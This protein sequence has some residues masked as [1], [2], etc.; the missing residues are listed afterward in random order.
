[1]VGNPCIVGSP[2]TWWGDLIKL[3]ILLSISGEILQTKM[4]VNL[5]MGSRTLLI[6]SYLKLL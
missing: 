5:L 2:H 3:R 4:K 1:M 6:N